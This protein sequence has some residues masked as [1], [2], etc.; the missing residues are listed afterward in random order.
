MSGVA[1]RICVVDSGSTD[2]TIE[3]AECLGAEIFHHE[4][5]NQDDA[6]FNWSLDKVG[7]K[8]V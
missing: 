8:T 2:R 5:L 7:M 4:P 6:Q 1:D 3:I